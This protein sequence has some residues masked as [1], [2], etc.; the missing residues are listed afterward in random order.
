MAKPLTLKQLFLATLLPGVIY[1]ALF[2]MRPLWIEPACGTR[3]AL[4]TPSSVNGFDQIAFKYGSVFADFCSNLIQNGAGFLAFLLPWL[5]RLPK[6]LCLRLNLVLL[7]ITAWNGVLLELARALV[8]RPRPL[9]YASPL[10][11]GANIHQY[12]SFYSGHTSFVTLALLFTFLWVGRLHPEKPKTRAF[13][14][15]LFPLASLSTGVLRVIGGRH[16]PTDVIAGLGFGSLVCLIGMR[17][18][19]RRIE[20]PGWDSAPR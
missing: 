9:V 7:M 14:A 2:G 8:Q 5:L 11:D 13:L 17:W 19:G 1:S 16:Y 18:A 4:C 20:S 6:G 3:P 12:T 10:T 15:L